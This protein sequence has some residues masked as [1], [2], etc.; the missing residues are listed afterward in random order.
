MRKGIKAIGMLAMLAAITSC[1]TA[2]QGL[3]A[4]QLDGDWNIIEMNREAVVPGAEQPFP[5]IHFDSKEGRI[6]GSAGCNNF[7]G[8]YELKGKGHKIMLDMKGATMMYCEDMRNEK[9]L[10]SIINKVKKYEWI[11]GDKLMLYGSKKN[12]S[13]VLKKK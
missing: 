11:D 8:N 3:T 12:S 5:Y 7:M 13:L 1:G 6:G 4:A 9:K 2:K 10:F